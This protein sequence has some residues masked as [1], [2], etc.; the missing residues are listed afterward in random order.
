MS[1]AGRRWREKAEAYR[2]LAAVSRMSREQQEFAELAATYERLADELDHGLNPR[3]PLE[4][5]F[6]PQRA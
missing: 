2:T 4:R 3:I 1:E 5:V 6:R